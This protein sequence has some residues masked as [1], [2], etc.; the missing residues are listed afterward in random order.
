MKTESLQEHLYF[1]YIM[2][3]N[4]LFEL[5]EDLTRMNKAWIQR[6]SEAYQRRRAHT[7]IADITCETLDCHYLI[8]TYTKSFRS[9][10]SGSQ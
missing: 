1:G 4:L 7:P 8:E 3:K 6:A 2:E 10:G 5:R 9:H